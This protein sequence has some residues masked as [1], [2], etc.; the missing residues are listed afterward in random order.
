MAIDEDLLKD[1]KKNLLTSVEFLEEQKEKEFLEL[2]EKRV[3]AAIK[4]LEENVS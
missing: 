4:R 1:F 3:T 2:L